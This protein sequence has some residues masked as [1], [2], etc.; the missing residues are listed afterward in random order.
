MT[1]TSTHAGYVYDLGVILGCPKTDLL[2]NPEPGVFLVR[3]PE[4]LS[5]IHVADSPLGSQLMYREDWYRRY[6]WAKVPVIPGIYQLRLPIH[7]SNWKNFQEQV[8]LLVD[9]EQLA[10]VALVTATMLLHHQK[11]QP[12]PVDDGWARCDEMTADG[13]HVELSWDN[14]GRLYVNGYWADSRGE[15]VWLAAVRRV[16]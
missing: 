15:S 11:R 7:D 10:P 9:G 8:T 1:T 13:S 16:S 6:E 12:D 14:Y 3:V 2:P 5:F 4:N